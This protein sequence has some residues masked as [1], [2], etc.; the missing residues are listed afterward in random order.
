M[1]PREI[2]NAGRKPVIGRSIYSLVLR[3][4]FTIEEIF[5]H[6]RFL[7]SRRLNNDY[8]HGTFARP[9]LPIFVLDF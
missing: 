9:C 5:A 1:D 4:F 2:F 6:Y 3:E 8:S 7:A